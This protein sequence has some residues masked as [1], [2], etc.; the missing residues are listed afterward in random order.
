MGIEQIPMVSVE[1]SL[2]MLY[3][4][5]IEVEPPLQVGHSPYGERRII[6]ISGGAFSGPRLSGRV[7]AGG[8]DWQ[9]IREDGIVEVEARYTLETRDRALI[10]VSNR[11]LRH[12]PKE[13]MERLASGE[14]VDPGEYYF[15]TIP[16]F[17]T[18]APSYRWLNGIVAIAAGE[19]RPDSVIITVYEVT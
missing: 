2:R 4:S 14:E 9:I 1:P 11:G 13:V 12:G 7:L 17:E 15:R 10:Y 19:R 18:G 5:V 6:N 3:T 8:A 16:I